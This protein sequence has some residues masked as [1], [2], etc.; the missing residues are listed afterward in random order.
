MTVWHYLFWVE[1]NQISAILKNGKKFEIIKFGGNDSIPYQKDFWETWKEYAGFLKDD[2]IDFCFVYDAECPQ[3]SE[4]LQARA[5]SDEECVW[6]QY[7]IQNAVKILEKN[8]PVQI[9]NQNG[10]CIAKVG[11]FRNRTDADILYFKA[12]YRASQEEREEEKE[13]AYKVTPF[14][15]RQLKKLKIYDEE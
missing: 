2:S 1:N 12:V 6:N 8:E 14:I 15:E 9:L 13:K 7:A 10:V 11:S 5:C 4:E 3:I